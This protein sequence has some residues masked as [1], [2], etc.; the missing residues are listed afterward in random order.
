M[1]VA[2]LAGA[3][4]VHTV[5]WANGLAATGAEVHLISAH[6]LA[7]ALDD[8]VMFHPLPVRAPWGYLAAAWSLRG[9][10][11]RIG[12]DILNAHYATGY[13]LL[14]RLSRFR[15]LLLSMWGSDVYDFP[16]KSFF[17]RRFLAMN[18]KHANALA[19]TSRCM[20]RQS[21]ETWA[22]A[23]VFIT[24]F[25]IDEERF[26]PMRRHADARCLVL[27]TV[28]AL[29]NKYGVDTLI[30]AFAL[31]QAQLAPQSVRL[32]ITGTGPEEGALK[33]LAARLGVAD[34]V[35]FHGAVE[36]ERVP[37]MLDRLDVF[38]ALSRLDSESFGVAILEAAA[39]G[40]PVVVS[41]ADGPA[42]VTID[43]STGFVVRRNDPMAAATA[44]VQL[45]RSPELMRE[46]GEAGR[47]H[48]LT[49][50]TWTRSVALMCEAY[51]KTILL[52]RGE[53]EAG[54]TA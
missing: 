31:A 47:R 20:A 52:H 33:A 2:L 42:E 7:G 54:L 8:T 21:A 51:R 44:I 36:H 30:E 28:K 25:G 39:A 29:K 5:R 15:P 12:P 34:S 1:K 14:A 38:A 18:L 32:E 9:V 53:S 46:M 37:L 3:H 17:H 23:H 43:G 49:H 45:A 16:Q 24:P 6:R 22:H 50:Y 41:D 40:K 26:T 35:I 19:S 27:G 10:L 11:R 4:S 48:V 13:G